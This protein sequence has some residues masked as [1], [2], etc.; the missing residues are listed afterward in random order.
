MPLAAPKPRPTI[1]I[2]E[3]AEQ[4]RLGVD[5]RRRPD[6][7]GRRDDRVAGKIDTACHHDESHADGEK[8]E[9]AEL[10]ED[11]QDVSEISEMRNGQAED[12]RGQ[13]GDS[14]RQQNRMAFEPGDPA[15]FARS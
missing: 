13:D 7:G 4:R 12:D 8:A 14:S 11:V 15:C 6:D 9:H 3:A 1:N 5:H 2:N 10:L